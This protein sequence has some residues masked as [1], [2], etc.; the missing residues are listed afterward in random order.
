LA[1]T[2]SLVINGPSGNKLTID[3]SGNDPTPNISEGNGTRVMIMTP[4]DL[5]LGMAVTINNL[6]LTGGDTSDFPGGGAIAA[7]GSLTLNN[8]TLSGNNAT[9]NGGGVSMPS[10]DLTVS[11]S[12]ISG[13]TSQSNGGGIY[14]VGNATISNST[15]S[16]NSAQYGGGGIYATKA[17]NDSTQVTITASSIENNSAVTGGGIKANGGSGF[18][19]LA[20]LSLNIVQSTVSGNHALGEG[21]G[22]GGGIYTQRVVTEIDNSTISGNTAASG[23]GGMTLYNSGVTIRNSTITQN[24]AQSSVSGIHTSTSTDSQIQIQS[25]IIAGNVG[26]NSD[27]DSSSVSSFVSLGYNLIGPGV[28]SPF[29]APGDQVTTNA[30]LGL[31]ANNGGPT[32]THA[33]LSGSPAIDAG[34]PAAVAGIGGVPATDQRGAPYTR[35]YNGDGIGGARIDIGAFELQSIALAS[36]GDYNQNGRVDAADYVLW[37]FTKG[38]NGVPALTGADGD[39]DGT[40]GNGD[41]NVWRSHFGNSA[42]G[43]GATESIG[44]AAV[45]SVV[46]D[47]ANW[48]ADYS[49]EA[50]AMSSPITRRAQLKSVEVNEVSKSSHTKA[51]VLERVIDSDSQAREDALLAWLGAS[52]GKEVQRFVN[53]ID[54][55]PRHSGSIEGGAGT[56]R[57]TLSADILD[58]FDILS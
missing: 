15:L 43:S 2:D 41:Y 27:L 16:G 19:T 10:G 45:A 32:K 14:I 18:F 24:S 54:S 21:V 56:E 37:R 44:A 34:D 38:T 29:N 28:T 1:I 39:G 57:K 31:L 52:G 3:A 46:S 49:V 22:I 26:V 35:V 13:N 47:A 50:P 8:C 23:G 48:S 11:S 9:G 4:E 55:L 20:T 40:I 42:A 51:L 53:E 25:S 12:T 58:R 5:L 33:L 30:K 7:Q 6:T 17:I 36:S